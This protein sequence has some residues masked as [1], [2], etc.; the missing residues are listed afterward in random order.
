VRIFRSMRRHWMRTVVGVI[1]I[2][3][4]IVVG[5]PFIYFH[6]V[7][8]PAPA[9][10]RLP[11]SANTNNGKTPASG[12][13]T[14]VDGVWKVTSGSQVGYRVQETLFAQS[15][16]A[17]GRTSAVTGSLTISGTNVTA[18]AFSADL[19]KVT[20]DQSLRDEQ[21]QG[22]IMDTATY[23]TATLTLTRPIALGTVPNEGVTVTESAAANLTMHGTTRTVTFQV[24]AR[25]SGA[26]IEVSGAIPITFANWNISNPSGGPA[27]TGNTGILE[28]LLNLAQ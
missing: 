27:T 6:F 11:S 5:G 9:P 24:M 1:L 25:H 3:A 16:T 7:E 22:R 15:H 26:T 14:T 8:G 2:V 18:A 21:F 10:L 13:E 4:V 19:T 23:P 28:F 17:V 20:S 12:T